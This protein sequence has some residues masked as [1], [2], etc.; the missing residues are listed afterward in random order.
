MILELV[1]GAIAGIL[2]GLFGIGGAVI[3]TPFLR[4]ILQVPGHIALGT[5]LPLV[6]PTAL[7]AVTVYWHKKSVLPRPALIIG[8]VGSVF[9]VIGALLTN[10]FSGSMM[11]IFTAIFLLLMALKISSPLQSERKTLDSRML[12]PIG[13]FTGFISGFLGIGGGAVLVPFL[14]ISGIDT[15]KA[16]GTS[17]LS[18]LIFSVPGSLEHYFLGNVSIPLLIPLTIGVVVGAQIGSRKAL[19]TKADLLE[20]AFIIFLIIMSF[21]LALTELFL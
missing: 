15:H 9:A 12:I 1:I 8:T 14:I 19:G 5:P 16:I 18:I 17:L 2:S 21:W 3:T 20:N 6:F 11:M 10:A 7:S 4:V 13:I